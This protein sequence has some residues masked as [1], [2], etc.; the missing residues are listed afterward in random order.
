MLTREQFQQLRDKGLSV[1]QIISFEKGETPADLQREKQT[2][3]IMA[4][5]QF[6]REKPTTFLGKA[7][8]FITGFIGGGKLAEG[9]GQAIAAPEVQGTLSEEQQQTFELQKKLIDRIKEKRASGEDA[10]RLERALKMSQDTMDILSDAQQDFAESLVTPKE[11][12][13]SS[14]RLATTLAGGFLAKQASKALALGK[15]TS[16]ASGA[17]RGAGVG[18]ITGVI[19]GGIQGAGVAAEQDKSGKE[20]ALSGGI[21]AGVGGVTGGAIGAITG[22]IAGKIQGAKDQNKL[23]EYVTPQTKE[24][25]PTEYEKALAQGKITPKTATSPAKYVLSD[26]EKQT[27][28]RFSNVI[29]KDP[30]KTVLNINNEISAI[31]DDVGNFLRE[32]NSIFN[33]GEVR[34]YIRSYVDDITDITIPEERLAKAKDLM[35]DNFVK[36]IQK[37]DMEGLWIARKNYDQAIDKAFSGSPTLQ[38]ELKIGLRNAVQDYIAE[39]TP[40]TVYKGFMKDMSQ[41]FRLRDNAMTKATKE[42]ALGAIRLWMKNNPT[43]TKIIGW[44]SAALSGKLIWDRLRGRGASSH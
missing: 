20:I 13:G 7:R 41:L 27:A 24:L 28:L 25:T 5:N 22:G 29:D 42:R 21:G 19:E 44:G 6:E 9:L 34:N 2:K 17:L 32:N 23:L 11:V 30:V 33:K 1:E 14:A 4:G 3:E 40:D 12:I 8:D 39:N 31:D 37:G 15:A 43:K 18:A 35:A 26:A 10:S 38:K 36:S 16:F